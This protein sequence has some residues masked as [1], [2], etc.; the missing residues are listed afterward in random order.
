MR[1]F[2]KF[3]GNPVLGGEELGTCFDVY[4]WKDNGK[5]RM[6]FS[7]RREESAAVSFS[8][9]GVTWSD[10]IITLAPNPD[11]GWEAHINRYCVIKTG[12][13]YKMYYTGQ[14]EGFS[15][16]GLAES[17]DGLHFKRLQDEPIL[18]PEFPYEGM[19]VMNPCVLC[20]DGVYKMWYAAGETYEP[21]Y[22]C[23]AESTDGVHFNKRKANPILMKRWQNYFEK[24]RL[25]GCQVLHTEDMG[26]L[27]FYIGYE[28]VDTARICVAR[29]ENGITGWERSELNPLVSPTPDAWDGDATYKPSAIWIPE[30]GE[31]RIYYNGRKKNREYVGFARFDERD[32][33]CNEKL[34]NYVNTFNANDEETVVQS[35]PNE[36]AYEYLRENAPRLECPD[37]TIEETFAFRTWT[38]RKHLRTTDEGYMMTEFLPKVSWAG[39]HNTIN[40]ALTH[41]LNEYRW[42]KNADILKDYALFFLKNKDGGAYNYFTPALTAIRDFLEQ[43]GNG[44]IL[45]ENPELAE[46]YFKGWEERHLTDGG[47]YKSLDNY[48][49]MEWSISGSTPVERGEEYFNEWIKT[50]KNNAFG[51]AIDGF[52]PTL[53]A[54]MY[55]DALT[56]SEIFAESGNAEK[57]EEYRKKAENIKRLVDERLW[58]GDFYKAVHAEKLTS[59]L[60][61]RDIAP[62]M[63]VRELIGYIPWI[64]SM[65][66]SGKEE[67]F[68]YLKDE[69]VFKAK[70]G[71]ATADK[72]H[73]R[74]LYVVPHECLWNGYVWPYATSQTLNAVISLLEHYD[75]DVITNADLYDFIKT[76]AEMHYIEDEKGK[77]SFIDEEMRPDAPVWQTR[78]LLKSMNWPLVKGG[79][80]RGKDYNHSTF[81][82]L[83]LRGLI[84][85]DAS[86]QTLVVKPRVI[87]VWKWFKVENLTFRRQTYDIYYDED[88][89]K[90]GKGK[91]LIIERK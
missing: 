51:G 24:D 10:P 89:T 13:V 21:N 83:V 47:L 80:E 59:D 18:V 53:N 58:D 44:D 85:I 19:S 3:S 78:E 56:L 35:V 48:D 67:A 6:D 32:L 64:Y 45:R 16:I 57:A 62:E 46:E 82:D 79:Y 39:R 15:Y 25:G 77:H 31:W 22:I 90:Y 74:Y 38:I 42:F 11:S 88:G 37:K 1:K 28:D 5:Y 52:R 60:S 9:D 36:K 26:Y 27:M 41:H 2:E 81:I 17:L 84:G 75:Q 49:A 66:S 65:P 4:V 12:G 71:F 86:A 34:K 23:Y 8:D 91:G 50:C 30:P 73:P 61:V 33:F 76:Y 54:Y 70:T 29:S 55:G 87:G 20:E 72:S 68:K 69:N 7:W 43:T 14:S 63:N 40:A